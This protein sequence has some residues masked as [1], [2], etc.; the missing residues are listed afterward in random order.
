[1]G[2]RFSAV[3]PTLGYL[4]QARYALYLLLQGAE[5]AELSIERFDDVA[6]ENDGT[7]QELIQL[8]HHVNPASLTDF[9]SDLWKTLR[10]WS[11]FLHDKRINLPGT[12]LTIITT[13]TTPP[14]S[15][16]SH[17]VSVQG[18]G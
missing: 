5:E 2:T 7:P 11:T 12:I 14:D 15:I 9:S 4:H 10:I 8:K 1:M 3:G 6:F 16:A 13:A 17:L 18:V